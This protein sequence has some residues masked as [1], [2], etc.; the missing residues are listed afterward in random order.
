MISASGNQEAC[1]KED[2]DEASEVGRNHETRITTD[3]HGAD[4]R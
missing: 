4:R 3:A 1:E 2:V